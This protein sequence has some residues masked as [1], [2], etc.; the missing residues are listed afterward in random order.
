MSDHIV[1][2]TVEGDRPVFINGIL[3][4]RGEDASVDLKALGVKELGDKTPGLRAHKGKKDAENVAEVQ[5][6]AVAPHAPDAPNPQGLAT[7]TQISGTGRLIA[8]ATADQ[9]AVHPVGADAPVT[10]DE[11]KEAAVETKQDGSTQRPSKP[12]K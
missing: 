11:R 7:G 9:P 8:P 6:A 1:R 4:L 12:A 3:H 5:I 10:Q 2:A